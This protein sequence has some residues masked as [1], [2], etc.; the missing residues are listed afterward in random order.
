M[1]SI[2]EMLYGGHCPSLGQTVSPSPGLLRILVSMW[3]LGRRLWELPTK[4]DL[5]WTDL[6]TTLGGFGPKLVRDE[7]ALPIQQP[8]PASSWAARDLALQLIRKT[9]K[10]HI[11][12]DG[13]VNPSA[14]HDAVLLYNRE[15]LYPSLG[16]AYTKSQFVS[17][18]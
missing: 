3:F 4:L 1:F 10:N 2:D 6:R 14:C 7:H 11:D 13:G 18:M 12:T 15:P 17:I 5:T 9:T 16:E 8:R